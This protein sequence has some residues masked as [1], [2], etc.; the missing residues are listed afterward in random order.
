MGKIIKG[1]IL[2]KIWNVFSETFPKTTARI[3]HLY[4]T[5]RW[6]N[7]NHPQDLNEWINYLKF[8]TDLNEW[9]R[10]ADKYAVREYVKERGLEN[11]LVKLFGKYDTVED[12]MKDWHNLPEKFVIKSN[13]GAGAILLVKDKSAMSLDEVQRK[14]NSM[15]VDQHYNVSE[16]HYKLIKN[17]II[18]EE[19]LED[20]SVDSFSCSLI[21]YKIWCFDGIP[22]SFFVAF[23]R[24]VGTS[25]HYFTNYDFNWNKHP[26]NMTVK[27]PDIEIKRPK[28]LDKMLEYASILS[29]GHPQCRVDLYNIDGCIYFGELTMTSQ[30]G[31]MDYFTKEYLLELGSRITA[32]C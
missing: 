17:C 13:N 3:L 15:L 32:K 19:L 30:G 28:N 21:D 1:K 23:D 16:P 5:G 10:M 24:E 6:P 7:I 25:H 27:S 14:A 12:L 9:A 22:Y 11:I 29:K 18:V 8:H 4:I 20:H 26:E 2:N 31:F